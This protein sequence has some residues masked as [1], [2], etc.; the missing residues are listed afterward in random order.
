MADADLFG[1][2]ALLEAGRCVLVNRLEHSQA[3]P[4]R[5]P[6]GD[7]E[8][9]LAEPLEGAEH[10][11]QALAADGL[12]RLYRPPA[13]EDREPAEQ[14]HPRLVQELVAPVDRGRECALAVGKVRHAPA[15]DVQPRAQPIEQGGDIEDAQ[16]RGGE[17]D[18]EREAV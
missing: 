5:C 6:V 7:Q 15:D 8:A 13:D 14:R 10:V 12:G 17:L 16:P 18:R 4:A 9:V 1:L 11:L 2:A 3:R